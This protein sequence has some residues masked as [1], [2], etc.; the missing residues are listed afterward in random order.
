MLHGDLA[1]L[2]V[3]PIKGHAREQP[4]ELGQL[5]LRVRRW[6]SEA[7]ARL[8]RLDELERHLLKRVRRAIVRLEAHVDDKVVELLERHCSRRAAAATSGRAS[9]GGGV[10]LAKGARVRCEDGCELLVR[11]MQQSEDLLLPQREGIQ[12]VKAHLGPHTEPHL[13]LLCVLI[14]EGARLGCVEA[15]RLDRAHRAHALLLALLAEKVLHKR[16]DLRAIVH[17]LHREVFGRAAPRNA[18]AKLVE[19]EDGLR[20]VLASLPNAELLDALGVH[21]CSLARGDRQPAADEVI[22]RARVAGDLRELLHFPLAAH[23]D[24]R[25][26][27]VGLVRLAQRL[28]PLVEAELIVLVHRE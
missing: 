28:E 11:G 5:K 16:D 1:V 9:G 21:E 15:H 2:G 13:V 20:R 4:D 23:V 18:L 10:G 26:L 17:L 25:A 3:E 24:A 22:V 27:A 14:G 6:P 7:F 12:A 19:A 8:V